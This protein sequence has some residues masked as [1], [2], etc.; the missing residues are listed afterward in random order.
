MVGGQAGQARP[1]N[2]T[3]RETFKP[4]SVRPD[5]QREIYLQA[6]R[7]LA[8]QLEELIINATEPGEIEF[9]QARRSQLKGF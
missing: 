3:V 2:T 8:N 9:W 6:I 4:K 5:P 1:A 7:S